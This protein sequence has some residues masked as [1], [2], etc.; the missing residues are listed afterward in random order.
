MGHDDN[1][2][3]ERLKS[4]LRNGVDNLKDH[5]RVAKARAWL[6]AN[7]TKIETLL[8]TPAL[9]DFVFEPLKGVF[10]VPGEGRVAEAR[11]VITQV[12]VVNAVIAGLPGS[13]G[14]GV[15]VSI[16]LELWM[17]YALSRVVGLGL[18]RDQAIETVI[19]WAASA[20]AVLFLFKQALNL[21]FPV[22]TAIMPFSGLGTALTQ[23][24]VTNMFGILFWIM[25]DELASGRKFRF[26]M[27]SAN[28]LA[29]ETSLL[30]RHQFA[31][32]VGA[33]KPASWKIMGE[34]LWAWFRGDIVTSKPT[35]R[36]E[37]AATVAMAWLING[38]TEKLQGP[39]GQEFIAAVRDHF[40]DSASEV[41]TEELAQIF[42]EQDPQQLAGSIN[43]VKG[44]LFERLVAK[45]ENA[46][47]DEWFASVHEQQN[48]PGSDL[49]LSNPDTGEVIE[50]SIKATDSLGYLEEA[51]LRYPDTPIIAT[52]EV[53]AAFGDDGL[54]TPGGMTNEEL[55]QVTE[56]NFE[57]LVNSLEPINAVGVAA[58]SVGVRAFVQLWPFVMAYIRGII[59]KQQ[60]TR[61]FRKVLPVEG[62]ALA[63]RLSYAVVL[64][65][66][67]A[68]WL[69]ARGI[70]LLTAERQPSKQQVTRRFVIRDPAPQGLPA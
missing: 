48:F 27:T 25:F 46:D 26:P 34:R 31:A 63:S 35:L 59:D 36:G 44:R 51:L 37:L 5:E 43:A 47:A 58:Q 15:Y 22:I 32:G 6:D 33:L 17:A 64:G 24:I 38:D 60:M 62:K 14:V 23:L 11:Q 20:G 9:R 54:V 29:S 55:T 1:N 70:L 7:Q 45:S 56:E 30:L 18:T 40:G 53:A 52:D 42:A 16:A 28:R 8:E 19:G 41:S 21:V 10:N 50:V 49:T 57:S 66:V 3:R 69:L 12:A 2:W 65:P 67:F 68:W 39:L 4:T 13:L 61:A